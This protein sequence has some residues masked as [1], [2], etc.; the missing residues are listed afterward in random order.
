M[1]PWTVAHQVPLS[2]QEF[3]SGLP[4]LSLSKVENKDV[5][6]KSRKRKEVG[7][8]KNTHI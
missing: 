1:T 7:K 5:N 4:L 3:Q 8:Y 2:R 6:E